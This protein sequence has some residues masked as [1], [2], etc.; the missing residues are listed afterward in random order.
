M[1]P[2]PVS[3]DSAHVTGHLLGV[4]LG[5]LVYLSQ[6]G[7]WVQDAAHTLGVHLL[8]QLNLEE[9]PR[10]KGPGGRRVESHLR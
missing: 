1:A 2:W 10:C 9:A 5:Q 7:F 4:Y 6:A 8:G 3:Y